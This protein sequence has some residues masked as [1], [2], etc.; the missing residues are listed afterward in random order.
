MKI[1]E[2]NKM[3]N[4]FI[5]TN[6]FSCPIYK[7]RIDP[8]SYD[9]EKILNDI[10]YNKSLKNTRDNAENNF[11]HVNIHHSYQDF[12]NEDFRPINYEK[13]SDVYLEIFKEFFEKEIYMKPTIKKFKYNFDIINYTAVTE[14]QSLPSHNHLGESASFSTVHYLNFKNDHNLIWFHNPA[15]FV[16][17]VKYLQ[18]ELHEILGNTTDNSY[19]FE[20]FTFS[21]EED[22]ILIFPA[23]LNHEITMQGPT[24]E[25]RISISSNVKIIAHKEKNND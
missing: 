19:L 2:D 7:I 20:H 5:K 13:L 12:D 22:D 17:Y 9:K 10:L 16:P 24:K 3:K 18:S 4:D 8:N 15:Q 6:L 1:S 14:G 25:P 23:S 11:G 21:V